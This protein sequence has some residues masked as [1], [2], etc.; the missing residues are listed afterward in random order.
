[1]LRR[2]AG[3]GVGVALR[4]CP[5]A[6]SACLNWPQPPFLQTAGSRLRA[7]CSWRRRCGLPC[8]ISPWMCLT[9]CRCYS[10]AFVLQHLHNCQV[11]LLN[12]PVEVRLRNLQ[13]C[14][15]FIGPCNG[16]VVLDDC[17][18]CQFTQLGRA[19]KRC[20]DRTDLRG[21]LPR[22]RHDRFGAQWPDVFG[23]L[24]L[25]RIFHERGQ[26]AGTNYE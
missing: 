9:C 10:R 23:E 4:P 26:I 5:P 3:A 15:V 12:R 21:C 6:V 14:R 8:L 13:R 16:P 19:G 11:L 18:D 22:N 2:W 1:M 17:H 7:V 20:R 24:C 25:R